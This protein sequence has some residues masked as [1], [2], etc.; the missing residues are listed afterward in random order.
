MDKLT[1]MPFWASACY[2]CAIVLVFV[3]AFGTQWS[4]SAHKGIEWSQGFPSLSRTVHPVLQWGC[5]CLVHGAVS[6]PWQAMGTLDNGPMAGL[7]AVRRAMGQQPVVASARV[8]AQTCG[9]WVAD[10]C[11]E[12]LTTQRLSLS[13]LVCSHYSAAWLWEYWMDCVDLGWPG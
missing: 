11:S 8:C 2:V 12:C 1:N 13:S 5:V 10:L 9:I 4:E 3:V 6:T 7:Y